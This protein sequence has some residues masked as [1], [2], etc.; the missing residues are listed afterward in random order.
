MKINTKRCQIREFRAKDLVPFMAY[1]NDLDWMKYQGFKGLTLAAYQQALLEA[2]DDLIQGKQLA[3]VDLD[4]QKL[5]GDL[6]IRQEGDVFHLGYTI[7]PQFARQGY[8]TEAVIA[9]IDWLAVYQGAR[10][11]RA[12][13]ALGN[14]NSE[15][16]LIKLG[17][18]YLT[19]TD[20]IK[21]YELHLR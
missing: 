2:N 3:V 9:L 11:I 20:Q 12:E 5:I 16:L 8:A 4:D 17:F 15:R 10:V 19:T 6:Y 1:H 18:Q 7:A 13:V 14:L 21:S